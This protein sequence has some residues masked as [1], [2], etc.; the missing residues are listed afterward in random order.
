MS[1]LAV[2]LCANYFVGSACLRTGRVGDVTASYR[3]LL[4][5][6]IHEIYEQINT[7]LEI[8]KT[9][10]IWTSKPFPETA[11]QSLIHDYGKHF[12]IPALHSELTVIYTTA[13][14]G[15][16]INDCMKPT[17]KTSAETLQTSVNNPS[18]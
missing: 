11:F 3:R 5:K 10:N 1:E 18:Y 12:D 16:F 13:D 15:N 7:R 9:S 6:V 4:F 17:V 14:I 8:L 2:R